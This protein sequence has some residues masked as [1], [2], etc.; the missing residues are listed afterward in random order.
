MKPLTSMELLNRTKGSLQWKNVIY[1]IKIGYYRYFCGTQNVYFTAYFGT[2]I[3][4][5]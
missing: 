1:I 3:L 5:V 4:S 2:L